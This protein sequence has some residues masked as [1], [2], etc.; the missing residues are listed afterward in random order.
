MPGEREE[1]VSVWLSVM[2]V[3][4]WRLREQAWLV[5]WSH[6]A[7]SVLADHLGSH[8]VM[9]K[10]GWSAAYALRLIEQAAHR[11]HSV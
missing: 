2:V 9:E 3:Y 11:T 1:D 5:C 4:D 7:R 6:H 10:T 8:V